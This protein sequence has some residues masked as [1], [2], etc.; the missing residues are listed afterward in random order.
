MPSIN[1]TSSSLTSSQSKKRNHHG[2]SDDDLPRKIQ[3]FPMMKKKILSE[4]VVGEPAG[5]VEPAQK[6]DLV[7]PNPK[8][9][10]SNT[11]QVEPMEVKAAVKPEIKIL[12]PVEI[13]AGTQPDFQL[14]RKRDLM[15][16]SRFVIL[17]TLMMKK[18]Y[19]P[20]IMRTMINLQRAQKKSMF[21][22]TMIKRNTDLDLD[23]TEY[24]FED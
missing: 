16:N 6:K 12:Q 2:S 19:L 22:R 8:R 1:P 7:N 9:I 4:N 18:T 14:Q 21:L 15:R 5:E 23:L 17:I 13:P 11:A 10:S 3:K 20:L 24:E